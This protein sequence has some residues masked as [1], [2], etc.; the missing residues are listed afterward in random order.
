MLETLSLAI[1]NVHVLKNLHST[2]TQV[3]VPIH[4]LSK[5]IDLFSHKY[6]TYTQHKNEKNEECKQKHTCS[7]IFCLMCTYTAICFNVIKN[8]SPHFFQILVN[9][10]SKSEIH[11][12]SRYDRN[13]STLVHNYPHSHIQAMFPS[14][15]QTGVS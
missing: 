4:K 11:S 5:S 7:S 3:P 12:V 14:C 8:K 2:S 15:L 13:H 6:S 9:F 1:M 10:P